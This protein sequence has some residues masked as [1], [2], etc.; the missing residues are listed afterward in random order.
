MARLLWPGRNA[1]G[2]CMRVGAVALFVRMRRAVDEEERIRRELQ[3]LMPGDAYVT[4]TALRE[5]VGGQTQS[6]RLGATM[7]LA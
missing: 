7:F 4:V 3:P 5:I 6:W 1:V 2:E